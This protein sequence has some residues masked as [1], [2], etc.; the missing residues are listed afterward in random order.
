MEIKISCFELSKTP[1]EIQK[2]LMDGNVKINSSSTDERL[3]LSGS[4]KECLNVLKIIKKV[5]ED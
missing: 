1:R 3:L 2:N 5:Y 4:L